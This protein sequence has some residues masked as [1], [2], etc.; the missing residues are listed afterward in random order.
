MKEKKY[1]AIIGRMCPMHLGHRTIIQAMI[2]NHGYKDSLMMIGSC[3]AP[4]SMKNFFDYGQRKSFIKKIFPKLRII[5]LPDFHPRNDLWL[6]QL[7]DTLRVAG[8]EP[9]E[10]QYYAGTSEDIEVLIGNNRAYKS[11]DRY[12]KKANVPHGL[13]GEMVRAALFDNLPYEEIAA[14][15]G[16]D[17]VEE[18]TSAWRSNKAV[19]MKI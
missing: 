10:V 13:S 16:K 4:Q 11:L 19:F 15:V 14:M 7:D 8:F 9:S 3:N 17:L 18:V 5:G 12:S 6:E 2:D 1:G